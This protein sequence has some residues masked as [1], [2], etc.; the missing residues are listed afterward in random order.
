[1]RLAIAQLNPTVGDLKGNAE[2]IIA[3]IAQASA[4]G[5]ELILF[6]ELALCGY[7]P[8]DL[9]LAPGFLEEI[10][11]QL[12]RIAA[13]SKEITVIL[14]TVCQ[15]QRQPRSLFNSAAIMQH[16][17]ILGYYH[18]QLLPNYDVFNERRYFEPGNRCGLFEINGK[19]IAITICEDIWQN[20]GLLQTASYHHDPVIALQA[21]RPDVLLNLSSS[22][23]SFNKA[24]TRLEVAK[25]AA[26]A[27]DCP[28]VL[29]NQVGANDSLLFDGYSCVFHKTG[30]LA[31]LCKG[32]VED[33][34]MIDT[35]KLP[36]SVSDERNALKDLYSAL[37]MGVR[38]YFHKSGNKKACL[39]LSG[40][41]DS[42]LV[43]CI[44]ADALGPEN[45]LGL[46]MPSRF[47]S[48]GS[49]TDAQALAKTLGITY[50]QLSIEPTFSSYLDLFR[51]I[52]SNSDL[53]VTAENLQARIRGAILM[54][55][56]NQTGA[57]LLNTGNK[58]ELAMG[59]CT[60]YGDM[61]G[62]VAVIGDVMKS[63][64]YELASLLNQSKEI[65][66]WNTIRKAPSAEL[67]P[68]Q[69]DADS[70]PDYPTL[71]TILAEFIEEGASPEQIHAKHGYPISFVKD[72][73]KRVFNNE[74]KR[75]QGPTILRVTEKA[76]TPACG[77]RV[78]IVQGWQ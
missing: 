46:A 56:A 20:S 76:L 17:R 72:I 4:G 45:V 7:P 13:E 53:G 2:R 55:Y 3:S 69:K 43:A 30:A 58:S 18:K 16:G 57:L 47:S 48:E 49:L 21:H 78:P 60:L 1:M 28:I 31:C 70:L 40:G 52:F 38:D 14:G 27:L 5:C 35:D 15:N 74:H 68:N 71:D 26:A 11:V 9:L 6:S 63:K 25:R 67:R 42:A 44:A 10:E 59:Y 41:I 33:L 32:F 66:P 24:E 29:C 34:C 36:E 77:R 61:C 64:V 50:Q 23:Y 19:K 75:R 8:E 37:V 12:N 51:N 54:A 22:P 39:G 65:I 62:A 73:V